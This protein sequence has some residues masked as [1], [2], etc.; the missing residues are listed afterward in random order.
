MRY[1]NLMEEPR[2]SEG[3]FMPTAGRCPEREYADRG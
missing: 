2:S 1:D 3:L